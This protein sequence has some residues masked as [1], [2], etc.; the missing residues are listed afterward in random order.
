MPTSDIRLLNH[1]WMTAQQ[2]ID[3]GHLISLVWVPGHMGVRG[4]EAVDVLSES[5]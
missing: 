3:S 5:E 1:T 4:N 2:L